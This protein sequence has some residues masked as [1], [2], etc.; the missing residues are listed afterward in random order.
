MAIRLAVQSNLDSEQGMEVASV[1]GIASDAMGCPHCGTRLLHKQQKRLMCCGCGQARLDLDAEAPLKG[2]RRHG[3][4][5]LAGLLVLPLP[6]GLAV[7]D[8]VRL[9]GGEVSGSPVSGRE[10]S[11]HPIS[12]HQSHGAQTSSAHPSSASPAETAV[13]TLPRLHQEP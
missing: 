12:G 5:L 2:L 3:P 6:L 9:T 8:G 10:V 13:S 7:L 1:E 4:L 11:D